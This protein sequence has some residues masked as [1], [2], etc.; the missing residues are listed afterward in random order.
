MRIECTA[1]EGNQF[2]ALTILSSWKY[3]TTTYYSMMNGVICKE[4][5]VTGEEGSGR[6]RPH[7]P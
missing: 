6:Q 5:T 3:H 7:A 4:V 2:P 1:I